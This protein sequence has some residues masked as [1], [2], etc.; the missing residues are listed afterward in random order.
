MLVIVCK[1]IKYTFAGLITYFLIHVKQINY[2]SVSDKNNPVVQYQSIGGST[3]AP[4]QFGSSMCVH[5]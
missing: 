3:F 1:C 2:I 5:I 4:T